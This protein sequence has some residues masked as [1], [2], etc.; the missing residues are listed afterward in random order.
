MATLR[1][2][3]EAQRDRGRMTPT[4]A[5]SLESLRQAFRPDPF[6]SVRALLDTMYASI[7]E[8]HSWAVILCRFKDAPPA[9]SEKERAIEAFFRAAFTSGTGA[10]VEYW[11]D[12]SLG[13]IEISGTRVFDWVDLEI[14]RVQAGGAPTSDPPGPGRAG[15]AAFAV[16]A[17]KRRFGDQ[18]LDGFKPI[19]VYTENWSIPDVPE[20]TTLETPG[21]FQFWID[22]SSTGDIICLT[23]PFDG[24]ITAHEMGHVLG[25]NH[26]VA[27]DLSTDY[28]DPSCIMSQ[29]GTFTHPTLQV[30]F[31]PALCLPHLIQKQWMYRRRLYV[32]DTGDWMTHLEGITLPLAPITRPGA[33]ANLGIKLAFR[34]GEDNWDY[35]LEYMVPTE[36]NRGVPG[37]P[38]LLIRRM[39][40]K[41]GGTPAYLTFIAVPPTLGFSGEVIEQSGNVNFRLTVISVTDPVIKVTAT[42]R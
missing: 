35:Y 40:P 15:L 9:L 38:Y 19:A 39:S 2:A 6:D 18:V 5:I 24:D 28:K 4:G 7:S 41:Y 25:M 31:G 22:G 12:V 16:A 36:W 30:G 27:P 8:R 14:D 29:N 42:M 37:A 32:D 13:S 20:G 21:F 26:D 3:V 11:R 1:Q 34:R 23:P 33:R 10:L 17:L